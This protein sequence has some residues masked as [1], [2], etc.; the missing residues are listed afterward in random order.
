MSISRPN[1]NGFKLSIHNLKALTNPFKISYYKLEFLHDWHSDS[2]GNV[3]HMVHE[4]T[5]L[6]CN[7]LEPF[8]VRSSKN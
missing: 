7:C 4:M 1:V 8:V 2:L 6:L 3:S 5:I